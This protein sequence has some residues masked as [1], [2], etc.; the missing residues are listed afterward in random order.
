MVFLLILKRGGASEDFDFSPVF[1]ALSGLELVP[2]AG[3]FP[4]VRGT[5]LGFLTFGILETGAPEIFRA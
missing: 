1:W 4:P 2:V 5:C 3:E